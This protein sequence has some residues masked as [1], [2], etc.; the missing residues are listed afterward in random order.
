MPTDAGMN[1][2]TVCRNAELLFPGE[3]CVTL[4]DTAWS[5][6]VWPAAY[7]VKAL[8]VSAWGKAR[9]PG[10]GWKRAAI[11]EHECRY[12]S[13]I[14]SRVHSTCTKWRH[15]KEGLASLWTTKLAGGIEKHVFF[16]QSPKLRRLSE[17]E[18]V[19]N[20]II[21]RCSSFRRPLNTCVTNAFVNQDKA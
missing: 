1:M 21:V 3:S 13:L 20:V 9:K 15:R 2:Y 18:A 11:S 14:Y 19:K 7:K 12:S 5:A 10:I 8:P 16:K 6:V 4:G 17:P